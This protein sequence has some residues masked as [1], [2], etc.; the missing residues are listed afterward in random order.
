[1]HRLLSNSSGSLVLEGVVFRGW[2]I[3]VTLDVK[4]SYYDDPSFSYEYGS[5]RGTHTPYPPCTVV[6]EIEVC[7]ALTYDDTRKLYVD[8]SIPARLKKALTKLIND[9]SEYLEAIS[10]K[11]AE[12]M[13]EY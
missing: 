7:T 10:Q 12:S 8:K 4:S 13:S 5:E 11:Y 1:M 2:E 9:S 6:E 3:D